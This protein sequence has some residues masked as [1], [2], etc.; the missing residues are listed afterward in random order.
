M[1]V[2]ETKLLYPWHRQY[3]YMAN[4]KLNACQCNVLCTLCDCTNVGQCAHVSFN[5]IISVIWIDMGC[6]GDSYIN[7]DRAKCKTF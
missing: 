7:Y 1:T 3:K 4:G 2:C 6:L 5:Q